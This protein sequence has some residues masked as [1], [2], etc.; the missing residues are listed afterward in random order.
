MQM[1]PVKHFLFAADLM[2]K[3][4][5]Y[6]IMVFIYKFSLGADAEIVCFNHL[7]CWPLFE[8]RYVLVT[9][10]TLCLSRSYIFIYILGCWLRDLYWF[11]IARWLLYG[12]GHHIFEWSRGFVCRALLHLLLLGWH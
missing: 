2:V 1:F 4:L 5:I 7:L 12:G 9:S 6:G 10:L 3:K 11:R 8:N